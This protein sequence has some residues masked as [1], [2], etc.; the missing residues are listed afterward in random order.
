M[1]ADNSFIQ[2][3]KP[4]LPNFAILVGLFL[5]FIGYIHEE[6]PEIINKATNLCLG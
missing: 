5:V 6:F 1:K 2:K 3:I 4:L